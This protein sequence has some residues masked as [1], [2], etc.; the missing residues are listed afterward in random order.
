MKTTVVHYTCDVCGKPIESPSQCNL[1]RKV[2]AS[3]GG[4]YTSVHIHYVH[5]HTDAEH[6]CDTCIMHILRRALSYLGG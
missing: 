1:D 6:I 5:D 2:N 3:G 4:N